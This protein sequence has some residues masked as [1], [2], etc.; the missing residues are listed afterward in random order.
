[1]KVF[2]RLEEIEKTKV[3]NLSEWLKLI[4]IETRMKEIRNGLME[5]ELLKE[6]ESFDIPFYFIENKKELYNFKDFN[7]SYPIEKHIIEEC[8]EYI[9]DGE[10]HI[11]SS[12][13][14]LNNEDSI[15]IV[16]TKDDVDP[17][18][19]NHLTDNN[20]TIRRFYHIEL[21]EE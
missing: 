8:D 3:N 6:N 10:Y 21:G 9:I 4:L 17:V 14:M 19:F 18:M 20:T 12:I 16:F 2:K 1:M 13:I 7:L 11:Y 15:E 5:E